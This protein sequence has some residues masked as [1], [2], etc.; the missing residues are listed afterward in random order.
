MS[1][2]GAW[3]AAAAAAAVFPFLASAARAVPASAAPPA[4]APRDL[5][6]DLRRELDEARR[7]WDERYAAARTDGE[8]ERLCVEHPDALFV[9]RFAAL[10]AEHPGDRI[11]LRSL[12]FVAVHGD[13]GDQLAALG[14]LEQD[15]LDA[16]ELALVCAAVR[17]TNPTAQAFLQHALDGSPYR[18]VRGQACYSL[19]QV[20]LEHNGG[21][22]RG[23]T[24]QPARRAEELLEEVVS[25]YADLRHSR[26]TLGTAAESDLYE[27]RELVPGKLAPDI[28]GEDVDGEP[29]RLSDYRGRVVVLVFWGDWSRDSRAAYAHELLLVKRMEGKPFALIGVNSDADRLALR[30]AVG[31]KGLAWRSFWDG[32]GTTG[33]IAT[34]WNVKHW[35]TVYVLDQEGTIRFKNLYGRELDR[36]VDGLLQ[37]PPPRN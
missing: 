22:V 28:A 17:S 8:R 4:R 36:A 6:D 34:R 37:E 31:Q 3:F 7:V 35:P 29:L 15:F 30:E 1:R 5:Y 26:G 33:P 19:A 24:A 2:S 9:P 18:E 10:A 14:P 16:P 21:A 27:L 23:G 32:G 25:S 13:Q 11:A 12:V 20:A